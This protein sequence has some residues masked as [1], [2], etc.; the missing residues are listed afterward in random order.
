M[1][2]I[3]IIIVT[4]NSGR[5]IGECLDSLSAQ[6]DKD[7][8]LVVIDNDSTDE[9]RDIIR[10]KVSQVGLI[11]NKANYGFSKG[12]NQ[13]IGCSHGKNIL[14]LNSDV[15][16]RDDFIAGL[17]AA[18]ARLPA[19]I[20]MVSPKLLMPDKRRID[21]TGLVLSAMRRFYDRGRGSVDNGQFDRKPDIFGPCAAA[22]LYTRAM[23]DDIKTNG[24]YFD[25]DFFVLLEDFDVAWRARNRGWK[26]VFLPELICFH[27]GGISRARSPLSEYYTFRNRY[28]LL[29]KN[30]PASD[31]ARLI[32]L[33]P[34]YEIP[35]LI[36]LLLF[37]RRTVTAL[38]EIKKIAPAM[39]KKRQ[40]K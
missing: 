29:L 33:A 25:E 38:K 6:T 1:A 15:V 36:F 9:T 20:G 14:L 37:N 39:L 35:R 22:A 21:S 10:R 27:H 28:L 3:S 4:Y 24:E 34:V 5:F 17:K 13:G 7:F 40:T 8:E 11:T 32:A 31:I 26:A 19:D 16:L 23:L 2:D 12:V 30:A 18:L